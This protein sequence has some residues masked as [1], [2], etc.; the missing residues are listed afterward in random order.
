MGTPARPPAVFVTRAGHIRS[1]TSTPGS[2]GSA[3]TAE[4]AV[5]D[6]G[7]YLF[8]TSGKT[9]SRFRQTL[10]PATCLLLPFSGDGLNQDVEVPIDALVCGTQVSIG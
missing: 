7:K 2:N 1:F 6:D 4:P 9:A 3:V 5:S 8:S 10:K